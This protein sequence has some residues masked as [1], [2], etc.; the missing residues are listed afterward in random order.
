MELDPEDDEAQEEAVKSSSHLAWVPSFRNSRWFTRGWTL[1]ELIAPKSV[2][3]FSIEGQ[4]LGD[5]IS[6]EQQIHEITGIDVDALRG[7]PLSQ[8]SIDRRMAWA[9]KR[10]TKRAEDA[11]YSLLGLFDIHI[12]LIYGEGRRKALLRLQNAVKESVMNRP[13]TLPLTLFSEDGNA[14][15]LREGTESLSLS[16]SL[17]CGSRLIALAE[18]TDLDDGVWIVNTHPIRWKIV[19]DYTTLGR[20]KVLEFGIVDLPQLV[21]YEPLADRNSAY[22]DFLKQFQTVKV[23]WNYFEKFTNHIISWAAEY[24]QHLLEA[25]S[26]EISRTDEDILV[27]LALRCLVIS[28]DMSVASSNFPGGE[29]KNEDFTNGYFKAA[30]ARLEPVQEWVGAGQLRQL[31]GQSLAPSIELWQ[32]PEDYR[33]P[34]NRK[35]HINT[36][37]FLLQKT[38]QAAQK[39]LSRDRP[40]DWPALFYTLCMLMLTYEGLKYSFRYVLDEPNRQFRNALMSL[41]RVFLYHCRSLHP[42]N[43]E[44]NIESYSIMVGGEALQVMHYTE[45]NS[46]WVQWRESS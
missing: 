33:L 30:E 20:E 6:L 39:L 31:L 7:I 12:P 4:R 25:Q 46:I 24:Q 16:Y 27:L 32:L 13:P 40:R 36:L 29:V 9:A 19:V 18:L 42:L 41:I 17:V 10:N 14:F 8:F 2:E 1:Q 44:L 5:R 35:E 45:M 15:G 28:H 3:F 34:N 38:F 26:Q 21:N 43:A 23:R 37:P 11:A 22:T